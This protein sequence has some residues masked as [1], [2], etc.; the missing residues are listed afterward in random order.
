METIILDTSVIKRS[1]ELKEE[2]NLDFLF[3]LSRCSRT[4]IPVSVK[5]ECDYFSLSLEN[6]QIKEADYDKNIWQAL[7]IKSNKNLGEAE[8][9]KLC[10]SNK[11]YVFLTDDYHAWK[12]GKKFL[13]EKSRYF[14]FALPEFNF[15]TSEEKLKI[16]KARNKIRKIAKKTYKVIKSEIEN[17]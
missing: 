10:Q 15:L 12:K 9:I 13:G 3:K 1:E 5:N 17:K 14:L 4:I 16:L 11:N 8:C 7:E 2:A 6:L